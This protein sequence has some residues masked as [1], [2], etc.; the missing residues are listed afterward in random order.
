MSSCPEHCSWRHSIHTL[1]L[2]FSNGMSLS[3]ITVITCS[4]HKQESSGSNVSSLLLASGV[5][6]GYYTHL[7]RKM[8]VPGIV[9]SLAA[10]LGT[11]PF[12]DHLACKV[13]KLFQAVLV[14]SLL[15]NHQIRPVFFADQRLSLGSLAVDI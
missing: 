9:N 2:K 10:S 13:S 3:Q 15:C 11:G 5:S 6:L 14:F 12:L 1:F 4:D 8:S 7:K